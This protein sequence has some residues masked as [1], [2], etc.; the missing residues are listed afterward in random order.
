MQEAEQA[1]TRA[2]RDADHRQTAKAS[3]RQKT[4]GRGAPEGGAGAI[5]GLR[6]V[7]SPGLPRLALIAFLLLTISMMTGRGLPTTS[8]AQ[9][10]TAPIV[11]VLNSS[12]SNPFGPYLAEILRTEG[13][14]AFDT[15]QL[16]SLTQTQ[17]NGY[18]M[19]IL[20]E[21]TLTS[22]QA[23]MFNS[24]V[25]TSGRSLIVMKPDSQLASM[26][27]I[28]RQGTATTV[29]GYI[30]KTTHAVAT[31]MSS[32][33]IQFKGTADNYSITSGSGAVE[34]AEL[35]S[36]ATTNTNLPAVVMD[37]S[38]G[39]GQG[40]V[41]TFTFDLAR[42]VALLRQG[43]PAWA[44]TDTDGD[45]VKRTIDAFGQKQANGTFNTWVNLDRLTIPQAD[46]QQRLL[47]N[48]ITYFGT[49][50]AQ[51]APIPQYWYFAQ[52]AHKSVMLVTGDDHGQN[53]ARFQERAGIVSAAGGR[54][55]FYLARFGFLSTAV[56]NSL[57]NAGHE[58]SVHPFANQDG[59]SLE[60][61]YTEGIQ[62]FTGKGYGSPS[63]TV[64][65]HQ[66]EWQGWAAAANV[67][68]SHGFEMSVDFYH[69]GQW[70][71]KPNSG[72]WVCSGYPT[73][74]GQ[75]MKHVDQNGA[76]IDIY[77]Q[78]T[79]LVDEQM[80]AGAGDGFCGLTEADAL[81]ESKDLIDNSTSGN[82][83]AVTVQAHVDYFATDWLEG[84]VTYAQQ[85]SVPIWT[86]QRWLNH[87]KVRHDAITDQ[88]TWNGAT[89][90]L[91]FCARPSGSG[92]ATVTL[93]LP[94]THS[95]TSLTRVEVDN[96]V[97]TLT[98]ISIQ[99]V[100]YQ[101][102]TVAPGNR[103]IGARYGSTDVASPDCGP[104]PTPTPT[105]APTDTATPT[106][107][108][109]NTPPP[110]ATSTFTPTPSSTPTPQLVTS[111]Q[112][113]T[114]VADFAPCGVPSGLFVASVGN[115]ELR[116]A[117]G[118]EDYFTSSTDSAKWAWGSWSGGSYAPAPS[119]GS[120]AVG[121][122]NG[123]WLRSQNTFTQRT[124]EGRL[125]PG[126]GPWQHVGF[127]DDGFSSRYAILSTAHDGASLR[128]RTAVN[129]GAETATV[130]NVAL[131]VPHDVRVVWQASKVDYY[132]DGDLVASHP[133]A[134]TD[135]MYV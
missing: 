97:A 79:Q 76:I 34:V 31:G 10:S 49:R 47:R 29:D 132:V 112:I 87:T 133:V 58:F 68:K 26:L 73:G 66:V 44:G 46:Q 16:G 12:S 110:G 57:R 94:A 61:G 3:R 60:D 124:L 56:L 102:F 109:T 7:L 114:A 116:R 83:A 27:G 41:A 122:T 95:G 86:V 28:T 120:L 105:S 15:V 63:K 78:V 123:V 85:K 106:A 40:R 119:G 53:D 126:A 45:G 43:N 74:S 100:S 91:Q 50:T 22:G 59:Q 11:L 52:P 62:W 38:V 35:Y 6:R 8:I 84:L 19:A 13:I 103:G 51:T 54:M 92:E 121:G 21:T 36:S 82:Y 135:P 9:G 107:T 1:V 130:L 113:D 37:E 5:S 125:T 129:G 71:K 104:S 93:L 90:T 17:L 72:P 24:Y 25:A 70:L 69:W 81:E 99:G 89:K 75:P 64:R 14:T 32:S 117:A 127:A 131:N 2:R 111:Q 20:A 134:I 118:L 108:F 128:A 48:I 96:Q 18:S 55:T 88:L 30:N 77:Q 98:A 101:A 33:T 65:N 23:S 39:S 80:V 42:S 67:A 4:S 115:G